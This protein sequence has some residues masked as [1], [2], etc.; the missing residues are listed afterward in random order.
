[1][2]KTFELNGKTYKVPEF[3]FNALV[4][5]ENKGVD[6]QEMT[7]SGK[8]GLGFIRALVSFATHKSVEEAGK[9]ITKLLV[10]KK[11]KAMESLQPL[12]EAFNDSDFFKSLVK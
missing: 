1:M 6:F 7:S 4:E 2:E 11:D 8:S 10:D 5:L 12:L 3:D 9:E